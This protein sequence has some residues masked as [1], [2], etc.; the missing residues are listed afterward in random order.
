MK[1]KSRRCALCKKKVSSDGAILGGLRAFCSYD[2]LRD[3]QSSERGKQMITKEIT[4][5]RN[6][7]HAKRKEK[8]KTKG[9]WMR[10][11]QTAFNTYIRWRDRNQSCI[12]CGHHLSHDTYGGSTDAGHYIARGSSQGHLLRFHAWNCHAQCVKCNRFLGGNYSQYRTALIWKIGHEKVEWL[13]NHDHNVEYTIDYLKRI[14]EV[15]TRKLRIKK[16][17]TKVF[18]S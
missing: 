6:Q 18:T 10:E 3:F 7:D 1:T 14:K 5:E 17:F 8:L 13:E 12:S 2:H 9:E 15:F 4:K 16:K 11:A